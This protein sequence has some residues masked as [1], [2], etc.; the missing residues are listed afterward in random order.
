[1]EDLTSQN[2]QFLNR[3]YQDIEDN[4]DNEN[5]GVEDLAES[6]GLSR[7]MLHRK[8]KKLTDNSAGD[9][10]TQK[11]LEKAFELLKNDVATASEIAYRV[12]FNSPSYF[13]KVFKKYYKASPGDVRKH[14]EKYEPAIKQGIK[15]RSIIP[16][17]LRKYAWLILILGN[18]LLLYIIINS[19]RAVPFSERDWIILTDFNNLTGDTIFDQSLLTALEISLQQSAYV[20][21]YP[22]TR[23]NEVLE[24]MGLEKTSRIDENLGIEIAKREGIKL[25][26]T[27]SISE[28]GDIY[29]VSSEIIEVKTG[30]TLRSQSFQA[31]GKNAVLGSLDKLG[32]K[33]RKDLGESL[34]S[35]NYEIISLPQA[36][37][38]SLEALKCF[39]EG[40]NAWA[41]EGSSAEVF[42][43]LKE[44]IR[45]DSGFALA[46]VYLGSLYYWNSVRPKGEEH[47]KKAL[48]LVDRLTEKEKLA[49]QARIER[50]RGNFDGAVTKY[51]V[52]LRKFP[53]TPAAWFS[54]GYSYM[55]L[56]RFDEAIEAFKYSL[57]ILNAED[58]NTYI[59]IATCYSRKKKFSE[60]VT[61]YLKAFEIN[62]ELLLIRNLNHEFGFNY[63]AM[64]QYDNALEV[65]GK[66]LDIDDEHRAGGLRS[67]GLLLMYQ[68]KFNEAV[69]VL[70][71][72]TRT[73]KN[74]DYKISEFRNHII[75][76]ILFRDA[77]MRVEYQRELAKARKLIETTYMSPGWL[78]YYGKLVVRDGNL[79]EAESILEKILENIN[80]G[81]RTDESAFNILK[82]EIE[83]A[84]GNYQEAEEY[85]K[86]AIN[87]QEDAYRLESLANFYFV[88]GKYDP[89]IENYQEIIDLKSLGWEAQSYFLE[90]HYRLGLIYEQLGDT[91]HAQDYYQE[92][93]NLWHEADPDIPMLSEVKS[94]LHAIAT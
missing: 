29:S 4:L 5:Y 72:S 36:T 8:L 73:F 22:R 7:S 88:T 23:I 83:L 21:V 11:R 82:G 30:E 85:L 48:A 25:I 65:F 32:R 55:M 87:I 49:I 81:N 42:N 70:E 24:R 54:L 14:P 26:V 20:N 76:A 59:N 17:R 33:L 34:K 80:K 13:N 16:V 39:V 18:L 1:M 89:A 91:E 62:P 28:I 74:L 41:N 38:S 66:M 64:G 68:G 27:C 15:W 63:V 93:S 53:D 57:S 58:A 61:N 2:E 43:L 52:Y 46:H 40:T 6:I 67:K 51:K 79:K 78:M 50:F 77:G 94:R 35:I 56:L 75:L 37:T 45:L 90:S 12:G 84:K 10:I 31:N 44:A 9:L 69:P 92:F 86:T 71:E 19:S 3:V 60:S 47:F